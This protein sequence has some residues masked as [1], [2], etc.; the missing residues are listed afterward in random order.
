[1]AGARVRA[2]LR[3]VQHATFRRLSHTHDTHGAPAVNRAVGSV[4]RPEGPVPSLSPPWLRPSGRAPSTGALRAGRLWR[5]AQPTSRVSAAS[6]S[7]LDGDRV[8][9]RGTPGL[10]ISP[11]RK[12]RLQQST[13]VDVQ[14]L[15]GTLIGGATALVLSE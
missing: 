13:F 4:N 2:R 12:P 1:M 15:T 6:P 11:A 5:G 8:A 10:N 9:V 3:P 14:R 7:E